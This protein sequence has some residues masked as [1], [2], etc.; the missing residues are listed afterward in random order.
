[1]VKSKS[2]RD[3]AGCDEI[4]SSFQRYARASPQPQEGVVAIAG[5][6]LLS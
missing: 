2:W 5:S 3:S 1:M 6:A 4:G